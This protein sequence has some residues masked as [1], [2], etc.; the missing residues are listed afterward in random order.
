M[1]KI[2]LSYLKIVRIGLKGKT[3]IQH[4]LKKAEVFQK[5]NGSASY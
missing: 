5:V 2:K 1:S 3:Y 4:L